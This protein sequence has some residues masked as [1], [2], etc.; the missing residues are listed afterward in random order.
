MRVSTIILA[1]SGLF[2]ATVTVQT[3]SIAK[4][5]DCNGDL[6]L[7]HEAAIDCG[8]CQITNTGADVGTMWSD[9]QTAAMNHCEEIYRPTCFQQWNFRYC[10]LSQPDSNMGGIG[11]S[12]P[13]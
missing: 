8:L 9:D 5:G 2:A 3:S 11:P 1:L 10:S 4:R 7:E 12:G 13:G 6:T